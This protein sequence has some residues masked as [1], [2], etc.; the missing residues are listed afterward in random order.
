MVATMSGETTIL[1]RNALVWPGWDAEP[2][3]D[4]SILIC[5]ERIERVGRF[6]ARAHTV[7]DGS[8]TLAMPGF[9]QAHVHLCQTLFRGA[10]EDRPLLN[11]LRERI[12]PLEAAHDAFTLEV[13]AQLGAAE[14]IQ[15]GTTGF[16]SIETVRGTEVVLDAI[17]RIGLPGWIG[18]CLM[19]DTAGYPPLAVPIDEALATCDMLVSLSQDHRWIR[20]AVAPRFALSCSERNLCEAAEF[21]RS[22]GL[23]LHT[24]ASEQQTEL[25]LVR[26]RTGRDNVAYFRDC[27]IVGPDVLLAHC[28]H[29]DSAERAILAES[30]SH[31]V[32]CPSAN[33]KLGSG[34][35]PVPEMIAER[36]AVCLGAD[37]AACNNRLDMFA[38]MRLAG[39][40][41]AI[42]CGPG[43]LPSRDI[44]RLATEGGAAALGWGGYVGRLEPGWRADIILIELGDLSVIP[45]EDPATAVVYSAHPGCISLTMAAGRILYENGTF[46]TIDEDRLRADARAARRRLMTRANL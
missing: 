11:W 22:R 10:A 26:Q 14:M 36:I 46:T 37:G 29:V 45:S 35:A 23:R 31:V 44:V 13:S 27:G 15:S 17:A 3:S 7:L 24:H 19:D 25:E 32:H 1:I 4:G 34:I 30:H 9:V 43:S 16:A 21:A 2:I 42:R 6:T 41:Q 28:V 8:G 20:P 38:E 39:L 12:W 40:A 18:H 5:G 33:W